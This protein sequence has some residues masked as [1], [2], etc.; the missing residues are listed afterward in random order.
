MK[1]LEPREAYALLQSDRNAVIVDVRSEMEFLFVGHPKD[2]VLIPWQDGE[3]FDVNPNFLAQFQK[4]FAPE[5]PII[6][7]CRS[8]SRSKIA[9]DFLEAHGFTNIY[10]V[11]YGFEGELDNSW[12]RG[13][14]N[15]WRYEGLPWEQT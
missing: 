1:H 9:G 4:D 12:R 14:I 10:N 2:A 7:I 15:G 3:Y 8:G 13:T 11:L 5:Q 6:L